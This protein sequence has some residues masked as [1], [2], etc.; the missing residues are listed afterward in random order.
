MEQIHARSMHTRRRE[1]GFVMIEMIL[2][3]A[4]ALALMVGAYWLWTETQRKNLDHKTTTDLAILQVEMR[5]RF[6]QS[7]SIPPG[8]YTSELALISNIRNPGRGPARPLTSPTGG[9]IRITA[10]GDS[11]FTIRLLELPKSTCARMV[12]IDAEGTA[13]FGAGVLEVASEPSG[14]T[15]VPTRDGPLG[16]LEM[17][18]MCGD[19]SQD[20][21]FRLAK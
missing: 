15:H 16:S 17:S 5:S 8:D 18:V 7:T 20:L 19:K 3:V 4:V 10:D 13:P 2:G 14:L 11:A 1:R 6:L 9:E 21:A 12:T